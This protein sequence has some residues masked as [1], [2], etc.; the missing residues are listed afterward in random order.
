MK[1]WKNIVQSSTVGLSAAGISSALGVSHTVTTTYSVGITIP[2]NNSLYS[3]LAFY[4][5]FY[6][7]YVKLNTYAHNGTLYKT[8]HTY[9]Y[10]PLKDT[11]LVVAYQ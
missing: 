6:K 9:H 1:K 11:Y 3:K 10:A 7:R 5:D 2:A 4:S 8:E